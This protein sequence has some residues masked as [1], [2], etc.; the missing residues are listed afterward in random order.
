MKLELAPQPIRV[1]LA[2]DLP[3]GDQGGEHDQGE[4]KR[5][6]AGLVVPYGVTAAVDGRM[7]EFEQGSITPREHVPLVLAHNMDRPIGVMVTS[8][9]G[10]AGFSGV[11]AVD[12]TP[13]GDIAIAQARSGSRRGLSAGVDV[14]SAR[15]GEDGRL[16]VEEGEL[17]ETSQ[18]TLAAFGSA[19]ITT[20]AAQKEEGTPMSTEE[21]PPQEPAEEPTREAVKHAEAAERRTPVI[22]TAD[23]EPPTMRLGEYVQDYIRAEKGDR[24]AVGRI[25]AALTREV[26][27]GSPGVVP[28]AYVQQILDSLGAPRS[29][30][31][32][33]DHAELPPAGM[34]V[35][36]PEVTARPGTT[37]WLAD[38]TAGAPSGPITLG[39][40][41]TPVTQWAWGVSASVALVERSAPSYVEEAFTQMLK[42][43][44]REVE[45]KIATALEA[46]AAPATTPPTT[47]GTAA[48]AFMAGYGDWPNILIAGAD[49]YGKIVD[50]LGLLRYSTGTADLQGNANLAGLAVVASGDVTPGDAWVTSRDLYELRE[51]TP[52]RLSVSDVTS[53]SL[54]MGVTSFFAMTTTRQTL[55]NVPGAIRVVGFVPAAAEAEATGTRNRS[56]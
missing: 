49:C 8:A 13:D 20:I 6:V 29:L 18:V 27:G 46:I 9:Q 1:E 15:E 37:G 26:V 19:G 50:A 52:I 47:L 14:I 41:D 10:E 30:F 7:I 42:H 33:F 35:R 43:Y 40:H 16:I 5:I 55:N 3:L 34:T 53:L 25:E 32:A 48:A 38:D 36:R 24:A 21:T 54:E 23:R 45:A 22:V 2:A 11:Y 12:P 51:S 4:P 28:I 56:R 17:A 39:A 31:G 44:Y